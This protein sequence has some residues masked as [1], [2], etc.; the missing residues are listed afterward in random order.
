MLKL[1]AEHG[2]ECYVDPHKVFFVMTGLQGQTT[3]VSDA[4]SYIGVKES[5][6][7]V[8]RMVDEA[9]REYR[10][11]EQAP[12]M[13]ELLKELEWT[14]G[15]HRCPYCEYDQD[16]CD[17]IHSPACKLAAVLKAVEGEA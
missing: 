3:I 1:T 17:G 16:L 2:C 12:A 6:D 4:N 5:A 13:Y 7:E 15:G 14:R 8:A 11:L 9:S 10:M